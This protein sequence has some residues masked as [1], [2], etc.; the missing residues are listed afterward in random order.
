MLGLLL[1]CADHGV[2][3]CAVSTSATFGV[4]L[5]RLRPTSRA[6]RKIQEK[7][8]RDAEGGGWQELQTFN[9]PFA[10]CT[11]STIANTSVSIIGIATV[12]YTSN[13]LQTCFG[14]T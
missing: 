1:F 13:V 5:A 6:S 10:F 3:T 4:Q 8:S 14:V 11:A 7:L 12:S 9:P 2:P